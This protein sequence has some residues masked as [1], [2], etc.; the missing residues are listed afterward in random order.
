MNI[1]ISVWISRYLYAC[2]YL[3]IVIDIHYIHKGQVPRCQHAGQV[4]LLEGAL[5]KRFSEGV[6]VI[7]GRAGEGGG[8]GV[9][10]QPCQVGVVVHPGERHLEQR[11]GEGVVHRSRGGCAVARPLHGLVH[12]VEAVRPG[13]LRLKGA[14]ALDEDVEALLEVLHIGGDGGVARRVDCLHDST[15]WGRSAAP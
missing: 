7:V 11:K 14:R 6:T 5:A 10:H 13:H 12:E 4:E 15:C 3:C 9:Q 8:G 2:R 1:S